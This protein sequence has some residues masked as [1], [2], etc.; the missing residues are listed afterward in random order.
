MPKECLP[1]LLKS[2]WTTNSSKPLL[3]CQPNWKQLS[4]ASGKGLS[5]GPFA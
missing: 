1:Q 3:I 4:K 5:H 2:Y